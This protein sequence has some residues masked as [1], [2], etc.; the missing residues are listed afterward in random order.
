MDWTDRVPRPIQTTL[1]LVTL[2]AYLVTLAIVVIALGA[3]LYVVW[4]IVIGG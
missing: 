2:V 3:L 4:P 1:I